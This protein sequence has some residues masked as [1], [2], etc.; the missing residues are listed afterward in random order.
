MLLFDIG[1][2]TRCSG[3]V[4]HHALSKVVHKVIACQS[5]LRDF[6][7]MRVIDDSVSYAVG[8][9]FVQKL[10]ADTVLADVLVSFF[11]SVMDREM[12]SQSIELNHSF[13]NLAM[14]SSQD[15]C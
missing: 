5:M 15:G 1:N 11:V 13:G 12:H 9:D 8:F 10:D 3:L 2:H 4:R 14:S 6:S 7:M